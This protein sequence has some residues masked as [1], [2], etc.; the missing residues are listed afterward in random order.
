MI[1]ENSNQEYYP[2]QFWH[3]NSHPTFH[4]SGYHNKFDHQYGFRPLN[5]MNIQ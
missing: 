2:N 3:T 1:L 5:M 4:W